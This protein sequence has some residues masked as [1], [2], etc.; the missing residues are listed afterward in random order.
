MKVNRKYKRNFWADF[1]MIIIILLIFV[2]IPFGY[3]P[4]LQNSFTNALF[5][6]AFGILLIYLKTK[7][8]FDCVSVD[9]KFKI[10]YY[11]NMGIERSFLISNDSKFVIIR[12][13]S[14]FGKKISVR[15]FH[16]DGVDTF[17]VLD[18]DVISKLPESNLDNICDK[19]P[20]NIN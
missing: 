6:I 11:N 12:R 18:E 14:I 13:N 17:V 9:N 2:L 3:T 4:T 1:L 15:I 10:T 8:F 5:I 7:F 16:T 20:F 19:N